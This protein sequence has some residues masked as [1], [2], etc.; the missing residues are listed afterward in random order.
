[1]GREPPSG[2]WSGSS[3]SEQ[4]LE[5]Y[6]QA[7]SVTPFNASEQESPI[8]DIFYWAINKSYDWDENHQAELGQYIGQIV[9]RLLFFNYLPKGVATP[10]STYKQ[11]EHITCLVFCFKLNTTVNA[12][13]YIHNTSLLIM[14]KNISLNPVLY[15]H[16]I[17]NRIIASFRKNLIPLTNKNLRKNK[18]FSRKFQDT[19]SKQF[20]CYL[21]PRLFFT[22][23]R[24]DLKKFE[25]LSFFDFF[26]I[27]NKIK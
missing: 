8:F 6:A 1:M 9:T 19:V 2:A 23:L 26:R 17:T 20:T 27:L 21:A 11:F 15:V 4:R 5:L 16:S 7:E 14:L 10:L 24:S 13:I 3:V 25:N 18:R 12:F 22:H